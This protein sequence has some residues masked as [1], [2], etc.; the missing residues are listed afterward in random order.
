MDRSER[1]LQEATT[2]LNSFYGALAKSNV[3][4]KDIGVKRDEQT[5][6]PKKVESNS[7]FRKR[8]FANAPKKDHQYIYAETKQWDDA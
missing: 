1:I 6:T 8:M 2:I 7:E 3:K 5:R 4:M